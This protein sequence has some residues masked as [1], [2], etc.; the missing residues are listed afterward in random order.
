VPGRETAPGFFVPG[1]RF[2]AMRVPFRECNR[3]SKQMQFQK[4][5]S[6]NPLGRAPGAR[7]KATLIAEALLQG[8]A[9]ELTRTAIERA[10]HDALDVSA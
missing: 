9:A 7:N 5:Q 8:E 10:Q 2:G 1:R 3:G 6:G 4:G